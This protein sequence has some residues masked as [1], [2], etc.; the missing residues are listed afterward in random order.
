MVHYAQPALL[1]ELG[2][3]DL[4]TINFASQLVE[5]IAI[6]LD[7]EVSRRSSF[8]TACYPIV[9]SHS[10]VEIQ[11]DHKLLAQEDEDG[12]QTCL[13]IIQ[14]LMDKC[15]ETFLDRFARLGVFNKVLCLAGPPMSEEDGAKSRDEKVRVH[16]P[17][18]DNTD[19]LTHLLAGVGEDVREQN[20]KSS[21]CQG[22]EDEIHTEDAR[23]IV[24]G[25]PYHWRDWCMVR[26]RDCLYIWSDA[27]ALELSNGSNGWFRF[28][29]DGKLATM[30]SS[31][32][33]EG[34]SDSSGGWTLFPCN[35]L[36][37]QVVA[38]QRDFDEVW[39]SPQKTEAS[40][41]RSCRKLEVR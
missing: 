19:V 35:S 29:L 3:S 4:L 23:E 8:L 11:C 6:V 32:S 34:G 38:T 28:I 1:T 5:V 27:A 10:C 12:H 13:Q 40:F 2:E 9:I 15:R 14:D 41:W 24:Q 7:S 37:R 21:L 33:P 22:E 31:G 26:G 30:Y 36:N 25:K 20:L 39:F 17:L 18:H 16:K